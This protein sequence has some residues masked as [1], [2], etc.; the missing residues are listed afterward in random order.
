MGTDGELSD[1]S[2]RSPRGSLGHHFKTPNPPKEALFHGSVFSASIDPDNSRM[3]VS[4][5]G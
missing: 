4:S 1:L 2:W 3:P 5:Q